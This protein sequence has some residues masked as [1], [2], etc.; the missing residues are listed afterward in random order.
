MLTPQ[1]ATGNVTFFDGTTILGISPVT[2]GQAI[3]TSSLLPSGPRVIR[4]YY[5]GDSAHTAGTS[6]VVTVNVTSLPSR[7]FAAASTLSYPSYSEPWDIVVADFNGDGL[8][9]LIIA[10]VSGG[11]LYVFLGKG[12]GTFQ[13]PVNIP[14]PLHPESIAV[15]DFNG[16][17]KPDLAVTTIDSTN[18]CALNILLGNGD[19]TFQPVAAYPANSCY[20][21]DFSGFLVTG[22]F[23][24]DGLADLAVASGSGIE[25]F[26]GNGDGTFQPQPA[27]PIRAAQ[28]L[29]VGDFNG[30][31]NADLA[32]V[33]SNSTTILLGNGDGTFTAGATL[34]AGSGPVAV[35]DLNSDGNLDLVLGN[36]S[37]LSVF[38]G[39][40][41]GTF[42]AI[43]PM[44]I[45][46]L[47]LAVGDFNG[48]G[49]PDLVLYPSSV[50][51]GNGDG[52]F[53]APANPPGYGGVIPEPSIAVADFNG[54]GIADV[55]VFSG[56]LL[57]TQGQ[58]TTT[59]LTSS[60][61]PSTY[62]QSVTLT[63]AVSPAQ[64]TGSITFYD[65]PAYSYN[66]L[67]NVQLS[68]GQGNFVTNSLKSASHS[69][70]AV[71]GGDAVYSAS[72]SPVL[73]QIV[74]PMATS[75][76][77]ISSLNPAP[78]N[79]PITLTATV[80]P[81]SATGAVTFLDSTKTLGSIPLS[82]GSAFFATTTLQPGL[83]SLTATYSGD[84]ND[85]A[86]TSPPLTETV[87]G[88]PT[89]PTTTTLTTSVK[90]AMLGQKVT[91]SAAVSPPDATGSV[92]FYDGA[93]VVGVRTLSAGTASLTTSLLPFG[94]LSLRASYSGNATYVPGTSP[95]AKVTL[96]TLPAITL[97]APVNYPVSAPAIA[98][99]IAD[100]NGDGITDIAAIASGSVS[101][102][103]GNG[104][105]TFMPAVNSPMPG[106]S[107]IN[108]YTVGDFN[109]DGNQDLA[110]GT[111]AGIAVLFG[112]GDGAF[113]API[114][115][116]PAV[117]YG[118]VAADFNG[119]GPTDLATAS[120]VL[121]SNGDGTF[122]VSQTFSASE[123]VTADFNGDGKADLAV[124]YGAEITVLLGKGDGTFSETSVPVGAAVGPYLLAVGD[125]NGDGIPDLIAGSDFLLLEMPEPPPVA[126]TMVFL[127]NGDGSF[128]LGPP[129]SLVGGGFL[130]GDFN[131]DGIADIA[132]DGT[133]SLGQGDGTFHPSS[134][135][136]VPSVIDLN[137][138]G[139]PDVVTISGTPAN[140]AISVQ[141]GEFSAAMV[142]R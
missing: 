32:A 90:S 33:S 63:A 56:V 58:P 127:G 81:S 92:T 103:L 99:V 117:Q 137:G 64:A 39:N 43:A 84:T 101:V 85:S 35:A 89:L 6:P 94:I 51:F 20:Y 21:S 26:L 87:P 22:D 27:Y 79:H 48:D 126:A 116:G 97:S 100:F 2:Q 16:D 135:T 1:S 59:A 54:D 18:Q 86:S 52:T 133:V 88:A 109:G 106:V 68:N 95:A 50:L 61:D 76:T 41:D 9:D 132:T 70:T 131:G 110:L 128:R 120:S 115:S 140:P 111:S 138:D 96:S 141:L 75:T 14:V 55:A 102:L 45:V 114:L 74:N 112:N 13:P 118:M 46:C 104:D 3:L 77:L 73:V 10:N 5:A 15:A 72:T 42:E 142:S 113:Q 98:I 30:D 69:M 12:D 71:Y 31:G 60:L 136:Y 25:L 78:S 19:G 24:G 53:Q 67:A 119:D 17:G 65:G 36:Q 82:G 57:G 29:A 121:L 7:G 124:W 66:A 123:I 8:A 80:S 62:S 40:G 139:R 38:L 28:S 37:S 83:H 44:R 91:L 23:N 130:V 11:S 107:N 93:D 122:G 47:G 125:F 4:A 134:T 129:S 105:G 34:P 49:I 108:A